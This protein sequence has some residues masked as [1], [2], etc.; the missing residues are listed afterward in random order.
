MERDED[1]ELCNEDGFVY[2]RIRRISDP[3][4]TTSNPVDPGLDPAAE[5]RNRRKRQKRTLVKLRS[6][7][8][9]EIQQWEIL[10]NS[11]D[12]MREKA[13]GGFQTTSQQEGDDDRLNANEAT[14]SH[15]SSASVFLDELLSMVV[16]RFFFFSLSHS[17]RLKMSLMV[18]TCF[19]NFTG[20]STRSDNQ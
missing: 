2:K 3:G 6:K 19:E 1:W 10:S 15:G 8:Q 11:F 12:A 18:C 13:A 5:E 14:S 9:R 4:E 16:V 17:I 7:Y 20:G